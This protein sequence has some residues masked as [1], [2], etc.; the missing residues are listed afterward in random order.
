MTNQAFADRSFTGVGWHVA[1]SWAVLAHVWSIHASQM[2]APRADYV[3]AK[4]A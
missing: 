2:C 3:A 4:W 1:V